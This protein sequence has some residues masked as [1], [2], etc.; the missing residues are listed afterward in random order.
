MIRRIALASTLATGLAMSWLPARATEPQ[1]QPSAWMTGEEIE[2]QFAGASLA[3]IY[4]NRNQWTEQIAKDGST[5]YREGSKH[6]QGRWW[7]DDREFCFE[8]PPPGLGGCFR[9]VK[10]TANCYELYEYDSTLG[11]NEE[12]PDIANRWNGRMWHTD[13][14]TTC[15]EPSV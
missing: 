10:R 7:V 6:W 11:R 13:R 4:P 3:G 15:E 12:P 8:Y 2:S 1:Q 9:I 14:P 5:D